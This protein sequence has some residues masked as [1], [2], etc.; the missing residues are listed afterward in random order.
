MI[1]SLNLIVDFYIDAT[2]KQI[3][4]NYGTGSNIDK[5]FKSEIKNIN[6]HQFK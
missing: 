2:N 5:S 4:E 1:H 6:L 3:F